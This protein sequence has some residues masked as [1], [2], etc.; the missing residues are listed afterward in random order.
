[1]DHLI[2][3]TDITFTTAAFLELAAEILGRGKTLRFQAR[4]VSM[5]PLVRDGDVLLVKPI[6]P[7]SIRLGDV[8]LC[9]N[10]AEQAV[11]HRVICKRQEPDGLAYQ[12]KGDQSV[13]PD[14]WLPVGCVYG[15]LIGIE[16]DG[17]SIEMDKRQ[18]RLL[19]WLAVQRSKLQSDKR[20]CLQPLSQLI[21][22]LP[23]FRTYLS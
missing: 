6:D 11:V 22:N 23:V 15:K 14:G 4:G 13:Q 3:H 5:R 8:V 1:M 9:K 7:Q 2:K 12:V 19:S 16:R 17:Q 10:Q 20:T 18:I 21:R